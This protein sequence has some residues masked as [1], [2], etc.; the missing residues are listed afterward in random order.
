MSSAWRRVGIGAA[1]LVGVYAII[2]GAL[3]TP[4][5]QRF[6]LYAHKINTLFL[7]DIDNGERFGFAKGQ[8]TPFTIQT[9]DGETLYAWHVLPVDAYARNER[10]LREEAAHIGD[11]SNKHAFHLLTSSEVRVVVSCKSSSPN[12]FSIL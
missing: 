8:V 2:L 3:L 7:H 1:A 9:A 10:L 11:F 4:N 5:L 6:A 12:P